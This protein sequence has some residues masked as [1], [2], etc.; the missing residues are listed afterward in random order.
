MSSR[1]T[2]ARRTRRGYR[3]ST[4]NLLTE[5]SALESEA[6]MTQFPEINHTEDQHHQNNEETETTVSNTDI[7]LQALITPR[8]EET[9]R[10]E[11]M[12]TAP[13][14]TNNEE[15]RIRQN[16]NPEILIQAVTHNRYTEM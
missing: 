7:L 12:R 3:S 14:V 11:E 13:E 16:N 10:K 6:E 15:I 1:R 4:E 9:V 5:E 2:T 8:D